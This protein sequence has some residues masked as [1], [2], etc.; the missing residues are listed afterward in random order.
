MSKPFV[1]CAAL[2]LALP[3]VPAAAQDAAAR[4][5]A[6]LAAAYKPD[7]PGA[8]VIVVKDGKTLLRK[9]YGMADSA[10]G[11]ALAPD[12]PMRLGSITKQFTATAILML[13][14]EGRLKLED[15]ITVYLPDYP[16][17][18]KKISIEHLLTHTSGIVSYTNRPGFGANMGRDM[19]VDAMIASFKDEPL[20]FDPGARY[21]YNNS[22]YFLL[23]AI[24]EKVSGMP[25]HEFIA[26]RIFVPLG[27]TR[28]AYEGHERE[29]ADKAPARAVGYSF[30]L[31]KFVPSPVLS[32]TQPYAAGAI[33]ST[34]DDLARW[35]AA[36]ANG[37][38]L[39]AA[40]WQRAF[41]PYVLAGGK[42]TGYGYGWHLSRLQSVPMIS[43][44]GDINGFKSFA[45]RLPAERLYVAV[46]SN[47]DSG[48]VRPQD[49]ALRAA[50][51]AIGKPFPDYQAISLPAAALDAFS[52][53]YR[54]EDGVVRTVR[55]DGER[56][57]LQRAGRQ[58]VELKAY[59]DQGFYIPGTL[60][61]LEFSRDAQGRATGMVLHLGDEDEAHQRTGDAPPPR[62]AVRID[63]A[64]F[65]A[66][67]GRYRIAPEL[68][69]EMTRDGERYYAQA[70]GQKKMEIFALNDHTFFSNEVD[71]ELRFDAAA[72]GQLLL[73]QGGRDVKGV[74]L[75]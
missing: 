37:K 47:S 49:A 34:V 45:L 68:V 43:H 57:L 26:R 15:D 66:Y 51:I 74:K 41:T 60:S 6:A 17:H 63:K 70:T 69:L 71:A 11:V 2:A 13:A 36:I 9:A 72:P 44:G 20:E 25:Y 30:K 42:G 56:F 31:G 53:V 48:L 52:G 16:T 12:T 5:D 21:K 46:L 32:M 1:V 59:S 55:R 29:A 67:A 33:V 28:S 61:S 8:T 27:M 3:A 22:G 73:R 38:L 24:V 7:A 65:D 54:N 39:K 4:I 50:A 75:P 35:D 23:G 62:S 18:G 19:T 10:R 58:P 64:R 14:D 40:S